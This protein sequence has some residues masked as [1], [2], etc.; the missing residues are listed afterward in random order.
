MNEIS[1]HFEKAKLTLKAERDSMAQKIGDE[2]AKSK[3][4]VLSRV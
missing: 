1:D 2:I 3:S 4:K